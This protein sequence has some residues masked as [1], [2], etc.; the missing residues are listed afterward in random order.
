MPSG[1]SVPISAASGSGSP[2]PAALDWVTAPQRVAVVETADAVACGWADGV[3]TRF[4]I[5]GGRVRGWCQDR[6]SAAEAA[7]LLAQ[8]PPQWREFAGHAAL[9]AA[10]L[11]AADSQ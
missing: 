11:A 4:S 8:T 9:L 7:P 1:T 3:L 2:L 5:Q 10:R 6:R